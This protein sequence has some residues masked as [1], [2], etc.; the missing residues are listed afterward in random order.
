[1]IRDAEIARRLV[2]RNLL[3][4]PGFRPRNGLHVEVP[5]DSGWIV[6]NPETGFEEINCDLP[7]EDFLGV[8][9]RAN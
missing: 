5:Q 8:R 9:I 1:L 3:A 2:F 7:E 4:G 6:S